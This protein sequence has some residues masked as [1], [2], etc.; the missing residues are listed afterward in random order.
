MAQHMHSS[1]GNQEHVF[2]RAAAGFST[3]LD[4]LVSETSESDT[5]A[6]IAHRLLTLGGRQSYDF[7]LRSLSQRQR[8]LLTLK[9]DV[10]PCPSSAINREGNWW[11]VGIWDYGRMLLTDEPPARHCRRV[12]GLLPV[13]DE[14]SAQVASLTQESESVHDKPER[15]AERFL[16]GL[17]QGRAEEL[18]QYVRNGIEHIDPV[19]IYVNDSTFTNFEPYN[20]LLG[21]PDRL[22][23]K[24]RGLPAADWTPD[25]RRFIACFCWLLQAG[26]RGEEFNGL[27]LTPGTL[28]AHFDACLRRYAQVLALPAIDSSLSIG[29]KARYVYELRR[30][31][32]RKH[33]VYRRVNGLNF[34]KEE[35]WAPTTALQHKVED[36]PS[37]LRRYAEETYDLSAS[38]FDNSADFFRVCVERATR[39]DHP[40]D[41][42]L[43]GIESLLERIVISAAE[44][45]HSDIGMTRGIRNLRGWQMALDQR[46]Y[47]E[48]CE[49]PTEEYFCAV[50]PSARML[51]HHRKDLKQLAKILTAC[52][53]RMRYNSWH[54]MPGHFSEDSIPSGRHYY[55]PPQMADMAVWSDQ[56]HAGHVMAAVRYAIRAPAPLEYR[57]RSYPGMIDLR[58][59]R[60]SGIGYT[61]E[62]LFT[63]MKYAEYLRSVYQA[64]SDLV[65]STSRQ[66]VI[67]SFDKQWFERYC[68]ACSDR[69]VYLRR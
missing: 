64:I 30:E 8:V 57:E 17:E 51:E 66:V 26:L 23:S 44:A 4:T 13:S 53:V 48:L 67:C 19:L 69:P 24:L 45:L 25:E 21:K 38:L 58:L 55:Y 15:E 31:M 47:R 11:Y 7:G 68:A 14:V 60:S 59:Y 49:W 36:L 43:T 20:N 41:G 9:R 63:A 29:E 34:Y 18:L 12:I 1:I 3:L 56:H 6:Q 32:R 65:A 16:D 2:N 52:S 28:D 22:F 62:E 35:D 61:R 40:A 5:L 54:Y 50:F 42:L 39:P 33:F 46:H 10:V 27:Q 37:G